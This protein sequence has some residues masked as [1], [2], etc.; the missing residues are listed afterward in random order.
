MSES[1]ADLPV[2]VMLGELLQLHYGLSGRL[3]RLDGEFDLN[4]LL[5]SDCGQQSIVKVMCPGADAALVEMQCAALQRVQARNPDCGVPRIVVSKDGR[6]HVSVQDGEGD[7]RVVW[8]MTCL[9]GEVYARHRP[10]PAVLVSEIGR[11]VAEIHRALADFVHPLLDR[12]MKWDLLRPSWIADR[13]CDLAGG[14]RQAT[15]SAILARFRE[16]EPSLLRLPRLPLHNDVNDYNI[17]VETGPGGEPLLRGL[18]DFGDMLYGPVVCELAIAGA[19]LVLDEPR[20]F[21]VLAQLVAGYHEARPL[22]PAEIDIIY[23]LLLT[24]LAVSVVNAALMKRERPGDPYVSVTEAPAWRFL[25]L[26]ADTSTNWVSAHLRRH[27]GLAACPESEVIVAWLD[28]QKGQ[29]TPI[30]DCLNDG[31]PCLDAGISSGVPADPASARPGELGDGAPP[32]TIGRYAEPRLLTPP[33]IGVPEPKATIRLG[34][35]VF[36]PAGEIVRTPLAGVVHGTSDAL[37]LRHCTDEEHIFF[38]RLTR[39]DDVSLSVGTAIDA[40]ETIGRVAPSVETDVFAPHLGVQLCLSD[41]CATVW[42]DYVAADEAET[43]QRLS[44][45]P[46]SLLG[47]DAHRVDGSPPE[48]RALLAGRRKHFADNLKVSYKTPIAVARGWKHFIYD[49]HGRAYLDAYNNVPHVGHCHPRIVAAAARQFSV[50]S[51]NTRYLHPVLSEYAEALTSK[52]PAPLDVCYFVNSASE[53]NE[54]ALRLARAATGARDTIVMEQG[55]HGNTNAAIDISAYKFDGPGGMGAPDWVHVVPQAD[56]YRGPFKRDDPD[57]GRRYAAFVQAAVERIVVGGRRPAAFI[58]ESLPSVGGQIVFP[59]NYLSEAYKAVRAAG[60]CCIADEVQTGL[61]RLGTHFWGFETQGVVPDIVVLGKPLGN[62]HPI[63]AVVTSRAIAEA[64]DN[65]MEFFSTFG[66][67]TVS[68]AV[69]IEV[70][71]VLEEERLQGQA[72][73]VGRHFRQRFQDLMRTH[74]II[75][76]VRGSGLFWGVE[77]VTDRNDLSPAT[78]AAKYLVNRMRDAGILIGTEGK[79]DNI[80]KVRPPMTFDISAADVLVDKMSAIM[81]DTYMINS[82]KEEQI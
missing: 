8:V 43:W 75:G 13:V 49:T 76:D 53:G 5:A 70:L 46:S 38:T 3:V 58:C 34:I 56:P 42:P 16:F 57:A 30:M 32:G 71:R 82:F 68:A 39:L 48:S 62:G 74:A 14:Q 7:E 45:N 29:L 10:R 23:P 60:G 6:S 72:E 9:P 79:F 66:G 36:A 77:L 55:Y 61:G 15:V 26:F 41:P 54:L 80:V 20:P 19:Y 1:T 81:N 28:R 17:M 40:G 27:C 63:G 11:T 33:D 22:T 64:F 73:T 35:D 52:L 78:Q 2:D 37:V 31:I 44:P 12:E 18:I 67:N 51:T 59:D 24:R 25:E 69:G 21:D 4:F 65:G 50:L 47:L